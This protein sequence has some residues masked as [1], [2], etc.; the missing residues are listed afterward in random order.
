MGS[1]H[2]SRMRKTSTYKSAGDIL[3]QRFDP[4]SHAL[5]SELEKNIGRALER[6]SQPQ[7]LASV[8]RLEALSQIETVQLEAA[9]A[10]IGE[11]LVEAKTLDTLAQDPTTAAR[12]RLYAR[13]ATWIA[14][15]PD[16]ERKDDICVVCG[17]DLQHALDPVT[18]RPVAKH[19]HEAASDAALLSQTLAR[20]GGRM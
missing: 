14:D 9:E 1:P 12:T 2:S 13:V 16:P 20:L 6:V 15:H 5:L 3:G 11:I 19:L 10:K 18:G 4:T 8:A 7:N 17:G